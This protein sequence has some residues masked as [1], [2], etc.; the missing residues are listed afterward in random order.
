MEEI[1]KVNEFKLVYVLALRRKNFLYLDK[2][3]PI[4]LVIKRIVSLTLIIFC[5][6]VER[7]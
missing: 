3:P 2:F 7:V 1:H 4:M 5:T 6:N